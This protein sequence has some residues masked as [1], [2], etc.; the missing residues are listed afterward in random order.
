M[1]SKFDYGCTVAVVQN[2]LKRLRLPLSQSTPRM[3]NPR[4]G[5]GSSDN[6]GVGFDHRFRAL[7]PLERQFELAVAG[8]I[9][10][11]L[12]ERPAS[13]DAALSGRF[14]RRQRTAGPGPE[15]QFDYALH[16]GQA[17]GS[18]RIQLEADRHQR[19]RVEHA[20][21][22][23]IPALGR[24][25]ADRLSQPAAA[26]RLAGCAA[27]IAGIPAQVSYHAGTYLCNATHVLSRATWPSALGL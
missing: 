18:T 24:R 13:H 27:S 16:L 25:R 2:S 6:H 4:A 8:A 3:R 7:R 15:G 5:R 9:D 10:P 22:R 12:P 19:G 1:T 26:G 20:V 11:E 17:P 14:R 21:A 23:S